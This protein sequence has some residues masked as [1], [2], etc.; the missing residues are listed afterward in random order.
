MLDQ[1]DAFPP[2]FINMV[3]SAE[4]SGNLDKISLQMANHYDKEY[5][6]NQKVKSSM[7]YPKILSVLIVIVVII[8]MGYVIPQFNDLFSQMDK[9]PASTTIMLAISN[10]VKKKWYV[11]LIVAAICYIAFKLIFSIPKVRYIKDMLELHLPVIG[12][13]R[14]VI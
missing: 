1:G 2:L 6:L 12:M 3:K 7:T 14:K 11:I 8:I 9:L 10:F 4:S 13:L 5:R